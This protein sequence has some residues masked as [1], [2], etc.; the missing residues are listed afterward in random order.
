M[1][2]ID[3][4]KLSARSPSALMLSLALLLASCAA[5]RQQSRLM[6]EYY[7]Q[8]R[9][10]N[11]LDS[12]LSTKRIELQITERVTLYK[13]DSAGQMRPSARRDTE[14]HVAVRDTTKQVA[15]IRQNVAESGS[16]EMQ[17]R[18]ATKTKYEPL[19]PNLY[20]LVGL[21]LSAL[22]NA[23]LIRCKKRN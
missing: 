5:K 11:R 19:G 16:R 12:L 17:E 14:T 2:W 8:E 22:I 4:I 21:V 18:V 15:A 1:K 6:E 23:W 10:D 3:L 13:P 7:R 9:I 20:L